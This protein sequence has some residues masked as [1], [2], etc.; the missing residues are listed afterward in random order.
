MKLVVTQ[1]GQVPPAQS[2]VASGIVAQPGGQAG[3]TVLTARV[4]VI[5]VV[6]PGTAVRLAIVNGRY[7]QDVSNRSGEDLTVYP[8]EGHGFVGQPLDTPATLSDGDDAVFLYRGA[9]AWDLAWT[10]G[11]SRARNLSE[12]ADPATAW[13]NLGG[14]N[15]G[16]L[17][18][19]AGLTAASGALT[20]D[21][22]SVA[23]RT[24]AV[25]IATGDVAG[26]GNSATRNVGTTAGS[27]AAGD[28]ARIVGAAAAAS[29]GQPSGI[30]SLGPDG[31]LSDAQIPSGITSGATARGL[32]NASTNTTTASTSLA[33]GVGTNGD[34]WAVSVA[35]STNLDGE[36]A[37][38]VGDQ[39][40]FSG[41][42]W[43][44]VP[45]STV[46]ASVALNSLASVGFSD[47]SSVKPRS[48]FVRGLSFYWTINGDIP[49][50]VED[51]GRL[52]FR[53][54][55]FTTVTA[56]TATV[57]GLTVGTV[58]ATT[59]TIGEGT[60]AGA[61]H[62][63]RFL[64]PGWVWS[65]DDLAGNRAGGW[66]S[67][68]VFD[69]ASARIGR[70][71][72]D[73]LVNTAAG[74]AAAD[75]QMVAGSRFIPDAGLYVTD[76][77][78]NV[79]NL[80]KRTGRTLII[81]KSAIIT[82][83]ARAMAR[84]SLVHS[85]TP[86]RT[87]TDESIASGMTIATMWSADIEFDYVRIICGQQVTTS[88]TVAA[89]IA[90]SASANDGVNPIDSLGNPVPFQAL[91][92][93]NGGGHDFMPWAQAGGSALTQLLNSSAKAQ[94]WAQTFSDWVQVSSLPR[95]DGSRFPLLMIRVYL[96]GAPVAVATTGTN[97]FGLSPT[98]YN[99]GRSWAAYSAAGDYVSSTSGFPSS[100][101]S[102]GGH[103]A[104]LYI[105]TYSRKWGFQLWGGG[106]SNTA[107]TGSNGGFAG[108]LRRTAAALDRDIP[109]VCA[110]FNQPGSSPDVFMANV[111]HI[112]DPVRPSGL[113][114]FPF[115]FNAAA[116]VPEMNENWAHAMDISERVMRHGGVPLLI[117]YPPRAGVT[118]EEDAVRLET[119]RR[120]AA[121]RAVGMR[122][123][124][125][126]SIISVPGT[127]E[128]W[129]PY[130][131]DGIHFNNLGH[132]RVADAAIVQLA[133]AFGI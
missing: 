7:R 32:W 92:W 109:V 76:A 8:P 70:L 63:R 113:L 97:Y 1:L 85:Y 89:V 37:W 17:S 68:G 73:D 126:N 116:T 112:I 28:D 40:L 88:A 48:K 42:A 12:V 27:V 72:V 62:R 115:S 87:G 52:W 79:G 39:A 5:T 30:A 64:T 21:V 123:V 53:T 13:A 121:C 75:N 74:G 56:V 69:T 10:G 83:A 98:P 22:R 119:L 105:Q 34:M 61:Q 9:E 29:V 86:P 16:K 118:A 106:D 55:R 77:S 122:T 2:E 66:R 60:L 19:G 24:G 103:W 91:R 31:R 132:S 20:A 131:D 95:T 124:D 45:L 18:V 127:P 49:G 47:G 14:G 110:N 82:R 25:T 99:Y 59:A 107:G 6:A 46:L 111:D 84:P 94:V 71:E 43:R 23:G 51:S 44:R 90:P 100:G 58:D 67:T 11:L 3:A 4:N 102:F 130:S 108:F 36:T 35:G 78:G 57:T 54:A 81:P 104:P 38:A 128:T 65:V 129:G 80:V 96:T 33:S 120:L 15:A 26:L 114:L 101:T 41:G 117:G 50:G 133:E 125:V 93:N